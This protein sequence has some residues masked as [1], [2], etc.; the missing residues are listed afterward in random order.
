MRYLR[1]Y[2]RGAAGA[3]CGNRTDSEQFNLKIYLHVGSIRTSKC[4]KDVAARG[5]CRGYHCSVIAVRSRA[6]S[7]RS[8]MNT[9]YIM[10]HK[11]TIRLV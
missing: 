11:K 6:Q 7:K 9:D 5:Y 1:V 3:A 8:H 2:V 10:G 4:A